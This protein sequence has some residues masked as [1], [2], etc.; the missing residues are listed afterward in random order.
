MCIYF[1]RPTRGIVN[2]YVDGEKHTPLA[3]I[4][5]VLQPRLWGLSYRTFDATN[6]QPGSQALPRVPGH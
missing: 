1:A 4:I 5:R 6:R 2:I 3:M